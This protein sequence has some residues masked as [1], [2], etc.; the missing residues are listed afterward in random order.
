LQILIH[1]QNEA[2][3]LVDVAAEKSFDFEVEAWV[4]CHLKL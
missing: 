4:A 3:L 1:F 2:I